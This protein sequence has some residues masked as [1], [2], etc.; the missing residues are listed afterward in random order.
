MDKV[1]VVVTMDCERPRAETQNTASGPPDYRRSELW[2]RAYSE[3]AR[4]HGYPVTFF[5]HPEVALAQ[6]SLFLEL[7]AAGACLGL[8]L[9]PWKFL[10]GRYD[11]HFG[12]LDEASQRAVLSEAGA[13]W[14]HAI[15]RRPRY[16]RPGTFSANDS[17]YRV[18]AELD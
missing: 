5:L 14:T 8:H 3:I 1:F 10:D 4:R 18:L 16:F 7:E 6:V 15:G 17:T 11:A 2:V 9:H 12:G 13:L